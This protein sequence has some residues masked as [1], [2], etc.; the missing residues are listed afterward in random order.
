V[1]SRSGYSNGARHLRAETQHFDG[2]SGRGL[3]AGNWNDAHDDTPI[4]AGR[5]HRE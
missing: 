5:S 3:N 1:P 2:D 4:A